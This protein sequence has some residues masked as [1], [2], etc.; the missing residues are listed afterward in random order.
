MEGLTRDRIHKARKA[1]V[2]HHAGRGFIFKLNLKS[3][4]EGKQ[5]EWKIRTHAPVHWLSGTSISY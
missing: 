4:L 1:R 2:L 5:E 3:V